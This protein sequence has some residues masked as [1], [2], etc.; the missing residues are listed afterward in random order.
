MKM[1]ATHLMTAS[2]AVM[3][4]ASDRTRLLAS[5]SDIQSDVPGMDF[6]VLVRKIPS[7]PYQITQVWM[8]LDVILGS[9]V[10]GEHEVEVSEEPFVMEPEA[11]NGPIPT[12]DEI[13]VV[14]Q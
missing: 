10:M 7:A 1:K 6:D 2:G 3:H 11:D 12:S 4:V 8:G 14:L 13:E 5:L 9:M